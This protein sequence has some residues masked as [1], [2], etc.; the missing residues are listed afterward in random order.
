[1]S[2]YLNLE[3]VDLDLP[4]GGR[5]LRSFFARNQR[6]P[7]GEGR[8]AKTDVGQ[9]CRTLQDVSISMR[10]GE[11]VGLIGHNGAGKS[12]L[13]RVLAGIYAPTRGKYEAHG[14]ISTL[15]SPTVGMEANASGR[16][17]IFLAGRTIGFSR[18]QIAEVTD[19]IIE[20]ADLG[21]FIEHP[22][23][24]YSAGMKTRLGFAIVTAIRPEIVLID[25]VFGAGDAGF[26]AKA[27]Q[28]IKSII[29]GAGILV[30][31]THS[32]AI[33]GSI[34]ERVICLRQ[35]QVIFDGDVNEG[36]ELYAKSYN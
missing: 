26:Y 8:I 2:C 25:E 31:A 14:Q 18:A 30:M 21:E 6:P 9:V 3:S 11:R 33:I 17:N 34:C 5:S 13:L 32:P 22:V 28:R 16:E 35:G 24:L 36:L 1:M 4:V 12:S 19:D 7:E 23:R 29:E 10:S 27:N 15:F 20:F